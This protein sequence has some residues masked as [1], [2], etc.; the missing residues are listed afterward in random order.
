MCGIKCIGFCACRG[1]IVLDVTGM[2]L[3]ASWFGFTLGGAALYCTLG[4]LMGGFMRFCKNSEI[5]L[6]ALFVSSPNCK[7][8]KEFG[9]CRRI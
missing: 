1:G 9:G 6:I 4:D 5:F 2:F 7:V 8:G 3:P